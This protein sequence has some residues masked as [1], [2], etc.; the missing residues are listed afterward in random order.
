MDLRKLRE[1]LSII[2]ARLELIDYGNRVDV[3]EVAVMEREE[4][5]IIL[6]PRNE[7]N[8]SSSFY[9]P[10]KN[11]CGQA[12][13]MRINL[14]F[15]IGGYHESVES[16][17][18]HPERPDYFFSWDPT[19]NRKR[20]EGEYLIG[21]HRGN[22]G[23]FGDLPE[24]LAAYKEENGLA[25]SGPVYTLYLHDEVCVQDPSQYLAQVCIAAKKIKKG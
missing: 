7:W 25:L 1:A 16:Y 22:Y 17:F 8:E 21:F 3:S 13:E 18:A 4:K 24:R 6:G 10:L 2:H 5:A 12:N 9:E 20:A 23:E 11:F 19:G 15:P 14:G